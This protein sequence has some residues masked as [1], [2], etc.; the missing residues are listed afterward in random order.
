MDTDGSR[1]LV[2]GKENASSWECPHVA[3]EDI[4]N[5]AVC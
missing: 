1:W 2:A 5:I 4:T 3:Y